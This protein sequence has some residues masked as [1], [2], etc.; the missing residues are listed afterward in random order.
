MAKILIKNGRIW[1]GERFFLADILT[2]G[3]K[4][5]KIEPSISEKADFVMTRRAKR[6]PRD[7]WTLTCISE[8]SRVNS[9]VLKPKRVVSPLE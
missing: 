9:L 6:F 8:G 5:S 2:D 3:D 4:I 7:L 1:D